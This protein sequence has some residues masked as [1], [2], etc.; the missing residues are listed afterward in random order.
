MS[1]FIHDTPRTARTART[2]HLDA[3][4]D[5]SH[6]D[7]SMAFFF[8]CQTPHH[9]WFIILPFLNFQPTLPPTY[10]PSTFFQPSSNLL[11]TFHS[12]PLKPPT[13]RFIAHLRHLA[14]HF[15]RRHLPSSFSITCTAILHQLRPD[16]AL[17]SANPTSTFSPSTSMAVHPCRLHLQISASFQF[18]SGNNT[19]IHQV[20]FPHLPLSSF[21][22]IDSISDRF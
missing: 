9:F 20:R 21:P 17:D 10:L 3:S 15:N 19:I 1:F 2:G 4:E 12:Q 14:I 11:P 6:H 13:T 22:D 16:H 18:S 5:A 7:S 8:V